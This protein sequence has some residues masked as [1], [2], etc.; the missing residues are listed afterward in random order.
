MLVENIYGIYNQILSKKN[1]YNK[2]ITLVELL[3]AMVLVSFLMWPLYNVFRFSAKA[4]LSSGDL[5]SAVNV[6]SELIEL[7]KNKP[8][9]SICL[10]NQ[11]FGL[12]SKMEENEIMEYMERNFMGKFPAASDT[13]R[14]Y[15]E[16]EITPRE[17]HKTPR[18][19]EFAYVEVQVRVYWA[20]KAGRKAPSRPPVR[21]FALIP[22]ENIYLGN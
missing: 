19:N 6:A 14:F 18:G 3:V 21:L 8:F 20:D 12:K 2:G 16:L 15:R 9:D 10:E 13:V 4:S 7:L 11:A 5:T 1:K 22:N 17:E